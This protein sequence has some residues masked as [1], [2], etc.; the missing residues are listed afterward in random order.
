MEGIVALVVLA[1]VLFGTMC[2]EAYSCYSKAGAMGKSANW[3]PLQGCMVRTKEGF[4]PIESLR[5]L[6]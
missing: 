1:V 4:M 5:V 2:V 3:G 6:E